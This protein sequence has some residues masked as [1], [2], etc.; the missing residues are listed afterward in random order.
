[1]VAPSPVFG[2][3]GNV[4]W[5]KFLRRIATGSMSSSSA[6][7]FEDA[8]HHVNRFGRPAPPVRGD[9]RGVRDDGLPV[10]FDLRHDVDVRRHHLA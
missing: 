8:F 6:A 2:M 5:M 1:M 10:V 9:G 4:G 3:Y 7:M